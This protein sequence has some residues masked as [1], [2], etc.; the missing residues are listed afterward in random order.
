MWGLHV[1]CLP[2]STAPGASC[3]LSWG[4][5][6]VTAFTVCKDA[7]MCSNASTRSLAGRAKSTTFPTFYEAT[8]VKCLAQWHKCH[9]G[10]RSHTLLLT[11]PELKSGELDRSGTTHTII[12]ML[13]G[14]TYIF[15]FMQKGEWSNLHILHLF[16]I[17]TC[18]E[19]KTLNN[20]L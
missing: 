17:K 19:T 11:A 8:M 1:G 2:K 18:V 14:G 6:K 9:D 7:G 20:V 16:N 12:L 3:H 15:P 10:I 5:N 4:W 13:Q